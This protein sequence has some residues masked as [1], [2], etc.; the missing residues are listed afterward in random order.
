MYFQPES[1]SKWPANSDI[2]LLEM[3]CSDCVTCPLNSTDWACKLCNNLCRKPT[4]CPN[5][6]SCYC[7]DCAIFHFSTNSSCATCGACAEWLN[8]GAGTCSPGRSKLPSGW[9]SSQALEKLLS[10][11]SVSHCKCGRAILT[12]SVNTGI[13]PI[14][15][16]DVVI[17]AQPGM[18]AASL[19]EPAAPVSL[20]NVIG[21]LEKA[22]GAPAAPLVAV[23]PTSPLGPIFEYFHKFRGQ[24]KT[25]PERSA[26]EPILQNFILAFCGILPLSLIHYFFLRDLDHSADA[27]MLVGSFGATAVLLYDAY[28]APLAQPRNLFGGHLLSALWG[29]GLRKWVLPYV[30]WLAP[31]LAVSGSIFIMDMT[32]TT[33]PPGGA[34][35]LIAVIGGAAIEAL[36]WWYVLIPIGLG[37]S[38][39]FLVAL[40]GNNIF[41]GRSYPQ[42]WW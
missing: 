21:A 24:G 32:E 23:K 11:L 9:T 3:T 37:V 7:E 38:I 34:T 39:M 4:E 5:C 29:M 15:N 27:T 18:P 13:Y 19:T 26:I 33:H 22:Q 28:K 10:G 8:G 1:L 6:A 20:P 41:P 30:D 14:R 36:G 2:P 31:T 42:Y 35:A 17:I 40:L 25:R 12:R 16:H